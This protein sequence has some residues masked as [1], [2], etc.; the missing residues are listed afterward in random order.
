MKHYDMHQIYEYL[1]GEM[2]PI[3]SKLLEDHI[4]VC[5]RCSRMYA[6]AERLFKALRMEEEEPPVSIASLVM[7]KIDSRRNLLNIAASFFFLV[8]SSLI[9]PLFF[10]YS[11]ALQFYIRKALWVKKLI[12]AF[13]KF[14]EFVPKIGLSLF[15][16]W[17]V[18]AAT[19]LLVLLTLAL[20]RYRPLWRKR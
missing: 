13:Y 14:I 5:E 12:K 7:E 6:Q 4:A 8:L 16:S 10:G 17:V 19:G 15:G 9:L 11:F 18:L 3:E 1:D 20:L 2:S